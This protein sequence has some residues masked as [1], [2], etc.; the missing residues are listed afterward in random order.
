[1]ESESRRLTTMAANTPAVADPV[2]ATGAGDKGQTE[3]SGPRIRCPLCGWKPGKPDR[4]LCSWCGYWWNTFDTG[5]ICPSCL[6]RWT[7]TQCL[8]CHRWSPHSDWYE[9]R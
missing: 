4:W 3:K 1:M 6:Y 8:A 9:Y 2:P 5:A 7:R